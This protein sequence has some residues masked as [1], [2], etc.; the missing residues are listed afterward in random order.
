MQKLDQYPAELVSNRDMIEGNFI[1]CLWS[2]P[3]KYG[4]YYKDIV[5]NKTFLTEDGVFYYSLGFEM[6]KNGYRSFDDA[7]VYSFVN[8]N[9]TLK[10]GYERRGGYSGIGEM[11]SIVDTSNT[12]IYYDNLAKNNFLL[13]LY[14]KGFNV[15]Q[16]I[17]KFNQ[18]TTGDIFDYYE[19]ILNDSAITKTTDVVIE[20]LGIDDEFIESCISGEEMGIGYGKHAPRLNKLTLGVPRGDITAVCSYTNGGKSSVIMDVYAIPIV[21]DG[22]NVAIISNEQQSKVYKLLLLIHVLTRRMGYFN[23]TRK[24]IKSGTFTD[25]DLVKIREAQQIINEEYKPKLKFV[26]T[27]DYNMDKTC[28]IIKQQSKRGLDLVIY[29]T[30]KLSENDNKSSWESLLSDS[31]QLF[32]AVSKENV[33]CIVTL[34]LALGMMNKRFLDMQCMANGKQIQEVFSEVIMSRDMWEDEYEGEKFELKPFNYK[35]DDH[36][37][38]SGVKELVSLDRDKKYKIFFHVKTRNDEA[39]QC[40]IFKFDGQWN[41][42]KELGY[43][44]PHHDRS[45]NKG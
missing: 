36:G 34:Q 32:Q 40:L 27:F 14:D 1:A 35:R 28:K 22:G 17:G 26:K 8:D 9:S 5:S 6:F 23:L 24:K 11:I 30:M 45:F 41:I 44:T 3:E 20:E 10:N 16:N 15:L 21:E 38:Y 18:M 25:E 2:E 39:N 42:W 37:R 12:D 4:D 13:S 7:S 31:K 19:Y 29:D 33:A 43:C